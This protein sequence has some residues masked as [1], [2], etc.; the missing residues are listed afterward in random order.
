MTFLRRY[1]AI[2]GW[3][4]VIWVESAEVASAFV[5]ECLAQV[6]QFGDTQAFYD[7]RE[8]V[9]SAPTGSTSKHSVKIHEYAGT[10]VIANLGE[11]RYAIV[12]INVDRGEIK[13]DPLPAQ[14][15]CQLQLAADAAN[16]CRMCAYVSCI[17]TKYPAGFAL[18]TLITSL[19]V[20]R[21]AELRCGT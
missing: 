3:P 20:G 12:L 19:N 16:Q 13:Y 6:T 10:A 14:D 8:H 1:L 2:I 15:W 9:P 4:I 5:N 18:R 7:A 21:S 17:R 11:N